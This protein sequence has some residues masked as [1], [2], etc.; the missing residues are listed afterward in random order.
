M[1]L[2]MVRKSLYEEVTHQLSFKHKQKLPEHMV[3]A[4]RGGL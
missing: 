4:G 1:Q 3:A 2:G